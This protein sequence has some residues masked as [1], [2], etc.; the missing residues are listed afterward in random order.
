M[1]F[2]Y[3]F[4]I[5]THHATPRLKTRRVLAC[6]LL[7][8]LLTGCAAQ[9]AY[10]D[11]LKLSANDNVEGGL[12]KFQEA[13]KLEPGNAEFKAA[14][15]RARERANRTFLEQANYFMVTGQHGKAEKIYQRV[16][17]IDPGNDRAL[18]GMA[19]IARDERHAGLLNEAAADLEQKDSVSAKAK[20][21]VILT[22][23]PQQEK[24]R[25]MLRAMEEKTVAPVQIGRAHV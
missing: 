19:L 4:S 20:L 1:T 24:A 3:F 7:A 16:L 22:E 9:N 10:Q 5:R 11:A 21:S 17:A 13:I 15:A 12:V 2:N 25:A 23:N 18:A 14:Y 6:V 8:T